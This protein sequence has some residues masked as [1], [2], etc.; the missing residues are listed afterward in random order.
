MGDDKEKDLGKDNTLEYEEIN[1][2]PD[3]SSI[4]KR[5]KSQND[6]INK[7]EDIIENVILTNDK[8]D[9]KLVKNNDS[10]II[11]RHYHYHCGSEQNKTITKTPTPSKKTNV[12]GTS[13]KTPKKII[14]TEMKL[15]KEEKCIVQEKHC[16]V[17]NTVFNRF[18]DWL[19]DD[20]TP[21]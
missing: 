4:L 1:N 5:T 3:A 13:K 7:H 15:Y 16:T 11:H 14:Q 8:K 17:D 6:N 2:K 20:P 12:K 19:H 21:L 18:M 9:T 10:E